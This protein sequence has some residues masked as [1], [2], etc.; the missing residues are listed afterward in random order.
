MTSGNNPAS[1]L[2]VEDD[3]FIATLIADIL[4]EETNIRPL[5]VHNGS[6]AIRFLAQHPIDLVILDY[7]LPG[8]NG[9]EVFDAMRRDARTTQT[10]V[11]FVTANDKRAEF[12]RRGLTYLRKPFSLFELLATVEERLSAHPSSAAAT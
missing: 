10:P 3:E 8:A 12:Q 9:L 2:I 11:L 1:V 5:I 6:E 4:R 7:Q